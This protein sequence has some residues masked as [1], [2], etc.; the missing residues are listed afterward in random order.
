MMRGARKHW[1]LI[2]AIL[3]LWGA[4]AIVLKLSLD[5]T[6]GHL[7]YAL[8]DAYI[9]MAMAK[10]FAEHGVWG[11][12]EYG[13]SSTSSSP[14]WTLIL[15]ATYLVFGTN[16]VSPF[17]LDVI[18]ATLILPALYFILVRYGLSW[19]ATLLVLLVTLFSAPLPGLVFTGQEHMLH[20]F[21]TLVFAYLVAQ[22]LSKAKAISW[23][24]APPILLALAAVLTSIRYEGLFLVFVVC[25]LFVLRRRWL[26]SLTLG[27]AGIVPATAYGVIS[28]AHGWFWLPNPVVLKGTSPDSASV[29]AV[30]SYVWA[31]LGKLVTVPALL[32]ITIAVL[33]LFLLRWRK[34]GWTWQTSQILFVAFM[35]ATLLHLLL[36][37]VGWFYRYEAYLIVFGLLVIW[38]TLFEPLPVDEQNGSKK[39]HPVPRYA[40]AA[41]LAFLILV[42]LRGRATEVLAQVP[43]A[44]GN[45]YEQQ[46]QMGLFLRQFYQGA[47]VTANDIGA[48]NYLADIRCVDLLGLASIETARLILPSRS[49]SGADLS[50]L[51][52]SKGVRIAMVYDS[53]F[54]EALSWDWIK[55]G[56]WQIQNNVICSSDTVSFYAVEPSEKDRLAANLKRFS[57]RL[58]D[59]VLE[60]G[61]YLAY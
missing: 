38:A 30:A 56:E 51:L 9:H 28:K 32:Y 19:P 23:A 59:D 34:Q 12:T 10:H 37:N 7:V 13:F 15:S 47:G 6:H 14:L 26:Q 55:V 39:A 36:A 53:C 43:Q 54:S 44:T 21:V 24:S 29:G 1:P 35:G 25:V 27:L 40:A 60:G 18:A 20:I 5:K 11:A 41:I 50:K 33:I 42:P 8:D 52:K 57:P 61:D 48:I 4:I 46:Y 49:C 16:Q 3:I 45:I 17:V 58:P 2:V 31:G 22:E